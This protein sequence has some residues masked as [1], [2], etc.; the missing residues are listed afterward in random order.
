MNIDITRL[1]SGIDE[2]ALIDLDY[3]FTLEQL[4]NTGVLKLDHVKIEGNITNHFRQLHLNV[5]IKGVMVL[6][7]SISLKP[8]EYP[9][10]I[11]IDDD[12]IEKE[13]ENTRNS[14]NSIDIFPIIWEN[15]VMEIP[16]KVVNDDLSDVKKEGNGWK[17][18]TDKEERINP[19]LEKLKDLL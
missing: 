8:T 10:T 14:G 3:S 13:L 6:P 17:F 18:I 16:L 15:I 5:V 2:Y 4:K 19:E 1:K 9:F 11:K 7:C 12:I